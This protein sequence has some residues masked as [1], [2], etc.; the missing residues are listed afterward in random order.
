M[1]DSASY[2]FGL[3]VLG[4]TKYVLAAD[5]TAT[6]YFYDYTTTKST[7]TL[8]N[9]AKFSSSLVTKTPQCLDWISNTGTT[10]FLTI[11]SAAGEVVSFSV[12]ELATS[13]T[14][15]NTYTGH[16]AAI[17]DILYFSGGTPSIAACD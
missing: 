1:T 13:A 4:T 9:S 12:V 17:T 7:N 5:N 2:F 16:S 8:A 14:K 10:H 15:L 3:A 11:G 6:L